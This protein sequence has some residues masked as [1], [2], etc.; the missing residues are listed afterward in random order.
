MNVRPVLAL[1]LVTACSQPFINSTPD[2]KS[3]TSGTGIAPQVTLQ[4]VTPNPAKVGD[5]VSVTFTSDTPIFS[6]CQATV[7]AQAA[8]CGSPQGSSCTCTFTVTGSTAEGNASISVSI[9]AGSGA[10]GS[11]WIDKSP[12]TV[13]ASKLTIVRH[14]IGIADGVS[15]QA[16]SASDDGGDLYPGRGVVKIRIYT[17]ASGGGVLLEVTPGSDGSFGETPLPAS[18]GNSIARLAPAQLWASAVDEAGNEGTRAEILSGRDLDPPIIDPGKV[19]VYRQPVGATDS[20]AAAA[21]LVSDPG[22]VVAVALVDGSGNALATPALHLDGSF[23]AVAIGDA[24]HTATQ[25]AAIATDKC[26]NASAPTNFI[27]GASLQPPT[28]NGGNLTYERRPAGSHSFVVAQSPA[29]FIAQQA[30][31]VAAVRFY[32]T[33]SETVPH[34]GAQPAGDGT[35]SDFDLGDYHPTALWADAIDKAGAVSARDYARNLDVT[36]TFAGQSRFS[37]GTFTAQAYAF[38]ADDDMVT[39]STW[40]GIGPAKAA[41]SDPTTL[42]SADGAK[43]TTT[44]GDD[45]GSTLGWSPSPV[46]GTP[47]RT[48]LGMSYDLTRSAFVVFGGTSDGT[49]PQ[50]DAWTWD[51]AAGAWT[52]DTN[53]TTAMFQFG[54]AFDGAIGRSLV[55][56]GTGP[57]WSGVETN[58]TF[59]LAAGLPLVQ[60][61]PTP[62]PAQLLNP[63]LGFDTTRQIAVLVDGTSFGGY[64]TS[65]QTWFF[66]GADWARDPADA[67]MPISGRGQAALAYDAAHDVLVLYGGQRAL[68]T[69]E[70]W[71]KPHNG[72]WMLVC[73]N[74]FSTLPKCG[75]GERGSPQMVFDP[76]LRK[77]ILFGG[78]GTSSLALDTW[79]YDTQTH[80]WSALGLADPTPGTGNSPPSRRDFGMAYDPIGE[81]TVIVGGRTTGVS[82]TVLSDTW[83]FRS[84]IAAHPRYAAHEFSFNIDTNPMTITGIYVKYVGDASGSGAGGDHAARLYIWSWDNHTWVSLPSDGTTSSPPAPEGYYVNGGKLWLL[85]IA[86]Y[87]SGSGT[88]STLSSDY[89]ELRVTYPI[90]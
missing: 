24:T 82:A 15:A 60:L 37:L 42:Q 54:F 21:G 65:N 12:P 87:P 51:G 9:G 48:Q 86:K 73:D 74:G 20:V 76:V 13:D 59:T 29:V 5:I 49:T 7:G 34:A 4:S 77:M 53:G 69:E 19:S 50:S 44:V 27:G 17:A 64:A 52:H 67:G 28:L 10:A 30:P 66:D 8:I 56:G 58:S 31:A 25:I 89:V 43:L 80:Q 36:M 88:Q 85:A 18:D 35:L 3:P 26:G 1:S 41:Q 6:A 63:A 55:Y 14:P 75:P 57:T 22:T 16:G 46:T 38:A 39:S 40:P 79:T 83:T 68:P 70:T 45:A 71:E 23:D 72:N 84:A 81:Q 62:T 61:Y 33:A 32:A 47:T 78:M 11:V 2:I 90:R